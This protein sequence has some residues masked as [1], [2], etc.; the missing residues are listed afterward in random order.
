MEHNWFCFNLTKSIITFDY[1]LVCNLWFDQIISFSSYSWSSQ[2]LLLIYCRCVVCWLLWYSVKLFLCRL[3]GG[4]LCPW[5]TILEGMISGRLVITDILIIWVV[6]ES[7]GVFWRWVVIVHKS[8]N[9]SYIQ[10]ITCYR[11]NIVRL[12]RV[13]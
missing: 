13:C 2:Y 9:K 6:V 3:W 8:V 1:L 7:V 5:C 11:L 10:I 4:I 12:N